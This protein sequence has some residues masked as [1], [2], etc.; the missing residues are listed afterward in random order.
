MD[1]HSN[2]QVEVVD[3]VNMLSLILNRGLD[4]QTGS[5]PPLEH[6]ATAVDEMEFER[7]LASIDAEVNYIKRKTLDRLAEMLARFK[8]P[9]APRSR[10]K[11]SAAKHVTSAVMVEDPTGKAVTI[12]CA[13][14]EGL[15]DADKRFLTELETLLQQVAMTKEESSQTRHFG[16]IFELISRHQQPRVLHYAEILRSELRPG[17]ANQVAP[18]QKLTTE[19]VQKCIQAESNDWEDNNGLLF[20]FA[21]DWSKERPESDQNVDCVSEKNDEN[22]P[23]QGICHQILRLL[24][25]FLTQR[26][27]GSIRVLLE[28]VHSIILNPRHRP[29]LKLLLKQAIQ[30]DNRSFG[31]AWDAL[32]YLTRI[33]DAAV[34]FVDFAKLP[35]ITNIKL[36]A[37]PAPATFKYPVTTAKSPI[38][39]LKAMGHVSLA[40]SWQT[41]FHDREKVETFRQQQGLVKTVHGEVQL[42]FHIESLIHKNELNAVEVFPYLGCSK[43]CCFFCEIFRIVHGVFQARGTHETLFSRWALPVTVPQQSLYVLRRFSVY[44]KSRLSVL[45]SL[46]K[47]PP[48]QELLRQSSA[49]LSTAQAM[50][51][52][53]PTYSTRPQSLT[54]MI[55]PLSFSATEYTVEFYPLKESPGYAMVIGGTRDIG[56]SKPIEMPIEEAEIIKVNHDRKSSCQKRDWIT[57]VFVCRVAKRPNDVDFLNFVIRKANREMQSEDIER[58]YNGRLYILADNHICSTFGFKNCEDDLELTNLV[59][60]YRTILSRVRP[61]IKTLQRELELGVLGEFL[62]KFCRIER[63]V[64]EIT[65]KDECPCVTWFLA[66]RS[67]EEAFPIPNIKE[68][69]YEI[70]I[71]AVSH[72]MQFLQLTERF[73][74]ESDLNESQLD[75][76]DLYVAIQPWAQRLPDI[77]SS[78]WMKFGFC[79]C[80]T[81]DQRKQL[82]R[83]YWELLEFASF[84]DIVSAYE[85]LNLVDLL[86][87]HGIDVPLGMQ[88]VR[89]DEPLPCEYSVYGLM[90]G[91]EHALSGRFCNCFKF[92]EGRRC[93]TYFETHLDAEADMNFGFH[94]TNDWE[95][96]QLLNFYKHLFTLEAF[97]PRKMAE[98]KEDPDIKQLERY[99]DTLV[100]DMRKKLRNR[101]RCNLLFPRFGGRLEWM[102]RDGERISNGSFG[103]SCKIHDVLGPPGLT[104]QINSAQALRSYYD[105]HQSMS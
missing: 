81:F 43:K 32:L 97:D 62:E 104:G 50:Q 27:P 15:D 46:P 16:P 75:V 37:V 34:A 70:W 95:R 67:S 40:P 3:L 63:Q 66:R 101:Y 73:Q 58:H 26:P 59:C 93:H 44:L 56:S 8:K 91:V 60:L 105:L 100:P 18:I 54:K 39:S 19:N 48:K 24:N 78:L 102:T 77:H 1:E 65:G 5:S 17:H 13:K 10:R 98:A 69:Q 38:E 85:T 41:F 68:E 33:F 82:A 92:K 96:W 83:K 52:D 9:N 87:S 11:N 30:G 22:T 20:R 80:R 79:H 6:L 35:D 25:S 21:R 23:I 90:I 55:M 86:R 74:N 49:A 99:L 7:P 64:A 12:F 28:K 29:V 72:A 94:L 76:F 51:G 84:D 103:C 42:I 2:L 71:T 14:N 47:P 88:E 89:P 4:L 45:L 61:A 36:Q 57:H 53:Q 31:K